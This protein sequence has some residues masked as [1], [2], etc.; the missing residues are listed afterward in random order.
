[1]ALITARL[2]TVIKMPAS[3]M[4]VKVNTYTKFSLKLSLGCT[5]YSPPHDLA[6]CL[7]H[8]SFVLTTPHSVQAEHSTL[9][10]LFSPVLRVHHKYLN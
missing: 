7:S 8:H 3:E 9:T 6:W 2:K 5:A 1:V 10:F 4:L